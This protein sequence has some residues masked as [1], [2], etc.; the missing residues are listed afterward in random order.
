MVRFFWWF[1]LMMQ[2]H[3]RISA[4]LQEAPW[5]QCCSTRGIGCLISNRLTFCAYQEIFSHIL[6]YL[7]VH[8][9][10]FSVMRDQ[11]LT[12]LFGVWGLCLC[13][14]KASPSTAPGC[15]EE[16]N[17]WGGSLLCSL[18]ISGI[19]ICGETSMS[20]E[21]SRLEDDP[22]L[23]KWL[24]ILGDMLVFGVASHVVR[25]CK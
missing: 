17:Y 10:F 7:V 16:E 13:S 5:F 4:W 25:V 6:S 22:F 15:A 23:G 11:P 1:S 18:V 24:P 19:K 3:A 21:T 8:I 9:L 20:P 2:F 14:S 12:P